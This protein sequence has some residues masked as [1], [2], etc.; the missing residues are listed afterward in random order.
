M[1][2]SGSET[3]RR[4]HTGSNIPDPSVPRGV[5]VIRDVAF[6]PHA[7]Q[8]YDVYRPE[9]EPRPLPVVVFFHPGAWS[10]RDKRAIRT[11]FVLEHGFALVSIGYR[12]AQ[13]AP[14]PA[15]V[16]DANA[17]LRH[18]LDNAA[19]YGIDL[20]RMVLA[21]TSAGAHLA[22]LAV[23]A[24]DVETFNPVPELS[25]RGVVAIYGAYDMASLIAGQDNIE[26]DHAGPDSPLGLMLGG[27]PAAY[28][29][30]LAEMSPLTHVHKDAPPFFVLHGIDDHVLPWSQSADF[31]A[32]LSLAGASAQLE[33]IPGAGHG[34]ESFRRPP[35]SDR[36]VAFI[37]QVTAPAT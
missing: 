34:H 7:R 35:I 6:G 22:A 4:Q 31:A 27:K 28:P 18:L 10:R 11:M 2:T 36:I 37:Q 21:G 15:Q 24:R 3:H 20:N 25:P 16:Q 17:G 8:S 1:T 5:T 30:R 19:D 9:S 32:A 13:Q 14:F 26:I 12:L 33:L 23:L 29:D